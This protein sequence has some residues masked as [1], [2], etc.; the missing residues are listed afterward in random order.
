M[1]DYEIRIDKFVS[2][3]DGRDHRSLQFILS[4]KLNDKAVAMVMAAIAN[5]LA[6]F[7]EVYVED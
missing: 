7:A 2:H 1:N 5:T 3:P 6:D 4:V